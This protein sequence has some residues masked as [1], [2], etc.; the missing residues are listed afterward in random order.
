MQ[1]T[2]MPIPAIQGPAPATNLSVANNVAAP[3]VGN[4]GQ[5]PLP[6]SPTITVMPI[7]GAGA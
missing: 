7:P 6:A 5:A 3:L 1:T 4:G 2:T